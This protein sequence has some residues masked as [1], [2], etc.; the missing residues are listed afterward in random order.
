MTGASCPCCGAPVRVDRWELALSS[1]SPL[2]RR[3][4]ELV[5]KR[6]GLRPLELADLVYATDP[7]GGPISAESVVVTRICQ[8]RP[9]LR[10]HGFEIVARR[11]GA[12]VG[13]HVLPV[14]VS[15]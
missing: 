9:R 10:A 14:E 1:L 12:N 6:P 2:Q 11:G 15:A 3:I 4:A 7:D 5:A 13:Y 8:M